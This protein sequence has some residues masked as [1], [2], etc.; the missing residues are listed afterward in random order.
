MNTRRGDPGAADASGPHSDSDR[1]PGS[2]RDRDGGATA[3][4]P[5]T[6]RRR[7]DGRPR[8]AAA[9]AQVRAWFS[10]RIPAGSFAGA[11][12][13]QVDREEITVVGTL[14][15]P[16]G[17]SEAERAAAAAAQIR[18]FREETEKRADRGSARGGAHLPP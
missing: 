13:V 5:A 12:D 14:A 6:E 18:S 17:D 2:D 8:R 10:G 16:A 15:D 7:C 9:A 11:P 4:A 3:A 1:D